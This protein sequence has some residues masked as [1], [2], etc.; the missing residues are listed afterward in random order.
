[1]ASH[2]VT[3]WNL[4]MGERMRT[5]T[6]STITRTARLVKIA[7][8]WHNLESDDKQTW[9]AQAKELS[10]S[11]LQEKT[12][13]PKTRRLSGYNLYVQ[14]QSLVLKDHIK[15]RDERLRHIGDMWRHLSQVEQDAWNTE[16]YGRPY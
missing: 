6:G 2:A 1:M 5:Y 13:S 16:A 11:S 8:E 10:L 12:S 14:E 15:D 4:F 7:E 3:G 9:N